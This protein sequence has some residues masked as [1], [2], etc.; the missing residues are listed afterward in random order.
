MPEFEIETPLGRLELDFQNENRV[1][2]SLCD[3][4]F[5]GL[6]FAS[7]RTL[8]QRADAQWQEESGTT[9]L[10]LSQ[11]Q[12]RRYRNKALQ[13]RLLELVK[14]VFLQWWTVSEIEVQRVMLAESR[15]LLDQ[16]IKFEKRRLVGCKRTIA[17]YQ[18][19]LKKLNLQI[20]ALPEPEDI[21]ES[22]N[23]VAQLLDL[24]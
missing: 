12:Y 15:E 10:S 7:F 17:S 1:W 6:P 8:F 20:A 22:D 23:A 11:Y 4:V 19:E 9:N 14:D 5:E 16:N 24:A 3:F 13:Q 18:A 2:L 21:N